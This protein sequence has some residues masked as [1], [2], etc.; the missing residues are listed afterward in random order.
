[1][2]YCSKNHYVSGDICKL[3][4]IR[5]K[6]EKEKITSIKKVSNKRAKELPEYSAKKKKFLEE[7]PRCVVFPKQTAI[8]IH[9][10]RG[11]IGSRFLDEKYWLQ[12]SRDGHN[13]IHDNEEEASKQ[14]WYLSRLEKLDDVI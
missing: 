14:G 2:G 13:W 7:N 9:H 3:C 10:V 8:D 1:M 4:E 12:V 5:I 11:K 6:P